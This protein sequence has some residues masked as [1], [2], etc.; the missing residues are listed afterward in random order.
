MHIPT[1]FTANSPFISNKPHF[2]F[3]LPVSGLLRLKVRIKVYI[4]TRFINI[5]IGDW[6]CKKKV[7]VLLKTLNKYVINA[8]KL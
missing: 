1:E 6:N 3:I 2:T 8:T 5:F 4:L 7:A